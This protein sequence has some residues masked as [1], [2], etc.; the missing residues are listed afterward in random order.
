MRITENQKINEHHDIFYSQLA[1][2]NSVYNWYI[3]LFIIISRCMLVSRDL[4]S[5]LIKLIKK[6]LISRPTGVCGSKQRIHH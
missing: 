5:F 3:H 6:K 1:A 4:Y 2:S